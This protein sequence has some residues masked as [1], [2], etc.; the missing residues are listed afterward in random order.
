MPKGREAVSARYKKLSWGNFFL[1]ASATV[2]PPTPESK[3][4]IGCIEEG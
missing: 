4:A 1:R 2:R 3:I